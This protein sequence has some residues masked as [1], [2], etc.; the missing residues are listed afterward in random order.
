ML[1][2]ACHNVLCYRLVLLANSEEGW[3]LV[4]IFPTY[5]KGWQG[6]LPFLLIGSQ[7]TLS[8]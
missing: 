2:I 1:E 6:V 3:Y 5:V 4:Q 7:P 8:L